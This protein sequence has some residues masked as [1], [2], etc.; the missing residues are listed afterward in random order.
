VVRWSLTLIYFKK[1]KNSKS[2]G[3]PPYHVDNVIKNCIF[4]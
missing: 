1:I 4:G 2:S 3:G